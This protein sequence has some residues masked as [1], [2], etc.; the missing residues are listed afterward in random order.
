M[1]KKRGRPFKNSPLVTVG[2]A[3]SATVIAD[4]IECGNTQQIVTPTGPPF[5]TRSIEVGN[6]SSHTEEKVSLTGTPSV[7]LFAGNR[8]AENGMDL[9]YIAP[10]VVDGQYVVNLDKLEVENETEK[11]KNALIVYVIGERPGYNQMHRYIAQHWNN[12]AE[13][14]LFLHEDGYYIVKFLRLSD[15]R[16]IL[17]GEPYTINSKPV[18]L[19]QWSPK[20][21]FN[22][23]FFT[24]ILLWVKFPKLLMNCWGI[25][26]LSKMASTLGNPLFVDQCTTKKTRLSYTRILIE[27]NVTKK[28]PT[29]ITVDDPSGRQFQQPIEFEWKPEFCSECLKIGHDCMKQKQIGKPV[30]NQRNKRSRLVP[31]WVPKNKEQQKKEPIQMEQNEDTDNQAKGKSVVQST[32]MNTEGGWT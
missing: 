17:Y 28:F 26:S 15:L 13:P 3:V 21:D 10:K 20:F 7:K 23:E 18:I 12:V 24:E 9:S 27:V 19:K 30:Q 2:S 1:A 16:E 29:E 25:N 8:S 31:T 22:A 14:D 32:N 11:W 5:T 4:T 6:A